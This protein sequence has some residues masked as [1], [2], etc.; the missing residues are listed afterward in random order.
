VLEKL[1]DL[2]VKLDCTQAEINPIV[3][4]GDGSVL[5]LDGKLNFDDNALFR[6]PEIVE[7]RDM[8]EEDI[9]EIEAKEKGLAFIQLDGD[10]GCMVNGAGLAMATLDMINMHGG[11]P[12]NFLDVGGSSNPDKVV[13]AFKLILASGKVKS[14]LVNIFGGIT[15]CTD[16]AQGM[17][18]ADRGSLGRHRSGGRAQDA[19]RLAPAYRRN[20]R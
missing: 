20:F 3:L 7:L 15:R 18:C 8:E 1:F 14:I 13:E 6:H 9:N 2:F 12:A 11:E 19:R 10:I 17:L 16:I 4:T 5:C